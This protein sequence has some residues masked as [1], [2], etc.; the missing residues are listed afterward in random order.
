MAADNVEHAQKEII[1][2]LLLMPNDC[3]VLYV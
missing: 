1:M 3:E 2:S